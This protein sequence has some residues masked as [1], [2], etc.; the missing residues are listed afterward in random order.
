MPSVQIKNKPQPD[1]FGGH[2]RGDVTAVMVEFRGVIRGQH[3]PLWGVG[4]PTA[5]TSELDNMSL[6]PSGYALGP[7]GRRGGGTP[8]QQI[9][10]CA[11]FFKKYKKV[12]TELVTK[13]YSQNLM[14]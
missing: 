11:I 9:S 3:H 7:T 10:F 1:P 8:D 13:F 14:E 2:G 4:P 6:C 5:V 12:T